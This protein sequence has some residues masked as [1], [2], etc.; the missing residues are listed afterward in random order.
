MYSGVIKAWHVHE[1]QV[2]WWYVVNGVVKVV[3]H[4]TRPN[5]PSYRETM[6]FLLGDNQPARVVR[7]PPG[8]AHGCKCISGPAN[9]FCV[10]SR[11]NDPAGE[12]RISHDDLTIGYDWF[13]GPAIKQRKA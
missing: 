1:Q 3:L 5:S 11:T 13:K 6:E 8:V 10:T 4:D 2:E 7:V 9:L 12:V